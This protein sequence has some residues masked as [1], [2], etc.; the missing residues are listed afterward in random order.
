MLDHISIG[1]TDLCASRDFYL[2]VLSPLSV[3]VVKEMPNSVGLG[4]D[5]VPSFWLSAANHTPTPLHLAF[6]AETRAQVD[7]FHRAALAA[8]ATDNGAPGL[9]S[10][11]HP[12][13]YG[14]FVIGP[15]G[16]NVEVVCHRQFA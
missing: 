1:V 6:T 14:A 2:T 8:G 5:G 3:A 4:Q 13:Y 9:R 10:G 12:N 16:H 7:A 11:Y 15:D